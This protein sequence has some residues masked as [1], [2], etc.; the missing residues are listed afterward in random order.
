ML[1]SVLFWME[2]PLRGIV[3]RPVAMVA[4]AMEQASKKEK[5]K[6]VK[7]SGSTQQWQ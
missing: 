4:V 2:A 3:S 5:Q 1:A 6:S 7:R